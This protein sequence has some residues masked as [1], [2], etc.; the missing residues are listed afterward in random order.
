MYVTAVGNVLISTDRRTQFGN[1]DIHPI[2]K[3]VEF[4]TISSAECLLYFPVGAFRKSVICAKGLRKQQKQS[5][6][7]EEDF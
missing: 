6:C 7:E 1:K 5:T 3:Y 2:V 4:E